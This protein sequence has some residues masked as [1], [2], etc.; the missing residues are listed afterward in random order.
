MTWRYAPLHLKMNEGDDLSEAA[1]KR[2]LADKS[3]R[4]IE[5]FRAA[6]G[7]SWRRWAAEGHGIDIPAVDLGA[8]K[9]VLAPAEAFVQY[10]L[11]AQQMRPDSFVMVMGY[12]ECAP[13][14][15]PTKKA[16][17]EGWHDRPW[18][19]ADPATAEDAMMPALRA[20][21]ARS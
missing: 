5:H 21:L 4:F 8:V 2:M 1:E 14:Y 17:A 12:G 10:Q 11:S 20:A 13:G 18:E 16:V 3:Q 7:L 9:L 15:I 19:W 6:S